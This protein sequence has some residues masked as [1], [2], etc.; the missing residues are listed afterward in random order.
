MSLKNLYPAY[1]LNLKTPRGSPV[2]FGTRVIYVDSP[3]ECYQFLQSMIGDP[4]CCLQ[5]Y[6]SQKWQDYLQQHRDVLSVDGKPFVLVSLRSSKSSKRPFLQLSLRWNLFNESLEKKCEAI[7]LEAQMQNNAL[8]IYDAI[9]MNFYTIAGTIPSIETGIEERDLQDFI[10]LLKRTADYY[11]VEQLFQSLESLT[12][13]IVNL[14]GNQVPSVGI[15]VMN[16]KTNIQ[17]MKRSFE[18]MNIPSSYFI[19]RSYLEKLVKLHTYMSLA[20][21]IGGLVEQ[22]LFLY[23]MSFFEYETISNEVQRVYGIDKFEKNTLKKF[24]KILSFFDPDKAPLNEIVDA[25]KKKGMQNIWINTDTLRKFPSDSYEL[26]QE[27]VF[28]YNVCNRVIHN[29]A[30][31]PFFSLLEVKF[32]KMFL[33]K[34]LL[35]VQKIIAK[36]TGQQIEMN[37]KLSNAKSL[38]EDRISFAGRCLKISKV[39]ERKNKKEIKRAINKILKSIGAEP[40]TF[41]ETI[42]TNPLTLSSLFHLISPSGRHLRGY[43]FLEEDVQDIGKKLTSISFRFLDTELEVTV[44]RF[45]KLMIFELDHIQLFSQLTGV[46]KRKVVFYLLIYYLPRIVEDRVLGRKHTF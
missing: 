5:T 9:R 21:N 3:P 18:I 12:N 14:L 13:S 36:I 44:E 45:R 20:K 4:N 39:L 37:Q 42:F 7:L 30:P 22:N 15:H 2:R 26:N 46:Q 40:G 17:Q 10:K 43:A 41:Y 19:L 38:Y 35:A 33:G 8:L 1:P 16:L 34:Y 24:R 25:M 31:L 6:V 28:L 29:Q 27:L 23:A 11:L 32:F